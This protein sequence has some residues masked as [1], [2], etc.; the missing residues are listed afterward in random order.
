MRDTTEEQSDCDTLNRAP[1]AY[2]YISMHV[3]VCVC[4]LL[5]LLLM[6]MRGKQFNSNNNQSW[7]ISP[8]RSHCDADVYIAMVTG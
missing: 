7:T 6:M 1:Y 4:A 2:V 3:S 8:V 5:L